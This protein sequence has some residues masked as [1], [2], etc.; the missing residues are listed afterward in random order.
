[1]KTRP[2]VLGALGL[3]LA[4]C[5]GGS[6]AAGYSCNDV[7]TAQTKLVA[8]SDPNIDSQSAVGLWTELST[9]LY[10]FHSGDGAIRAAASASISAS[11]SVPPEAGDLAVVNQALVAASKTCS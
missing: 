6:T 4:G 2:V 3:L 8:A 11:T 7:R 5:G 9:S 10:R 1:M